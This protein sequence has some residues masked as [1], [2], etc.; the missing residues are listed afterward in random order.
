VAKFAPNIRGIGLPNFLWYQVVNMLYHTEQDVQDDL[1]C[2]FSI[3]GLCSLKKSC[4]N[5]A[6]W[7]YV[8]KI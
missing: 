6:V 2:T 5:Y 8:F 4:D 7:D 1:S 3:D